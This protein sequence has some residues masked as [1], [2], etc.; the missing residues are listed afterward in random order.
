[1]PMTNEKAAHTARNPVA[2]GGEPPYDEDMEARI[3]KLEEFAADT[4]ERLVRIETR[5]DQMATKAD[6]AELKAQL[7]HSVNELIRWMVGIAL[8]I[9]VTAITVMTFVLNNATPKAPAQPPTPIIIY[10]QPAPAAG[11]P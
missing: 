5:L 3:A 9:S 1:M 11:H 7:Q 8:G 2:A 6:L 10:T 4:K